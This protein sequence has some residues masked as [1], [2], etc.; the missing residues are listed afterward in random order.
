MSQDKVATD[1]W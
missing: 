1:S